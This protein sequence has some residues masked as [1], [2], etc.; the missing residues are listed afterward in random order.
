MRFNNFLTAAASIAAFAGLISDARATY[1]TSNGTVQVSSDTHIAPPL[2]NIQQLSGPTSGGYVYTNQVS[3]SPFTSGNIR[4]ISV[5]RVNEA[6]LNQ[7]NIKVGMNASPGTALV[8]VT[9]LKGTL[10]GGGTASFSQ[11]TLFLIA[12]PSATFS[13]TDPDT[14]AKPADAAI[15]AQYSLVKDSVINGP[16]QASVP[17]IIGTT[18]DPA[19]TT[20]ALMNLSSISVLQGQ[21]VG[22]FLFT[23]NSLPV[24]NS[25]TSGDNFIRDVQNI[26]GLTSIHDG[27]YVTITQN[28]QNITGLTDASAGLALGATDLTVLNDYAGAASL[29]DL[30]LPGTAFA[31]AYGATNTGPPG[32][33]F[34]P[35][36]SGA[37]TNKTGDFLATLASN[38]NIVTVPVPE[39]DSFVLFGLG[40]A[41]LAAV[42]FRN[43]KK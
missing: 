36:G 25:P 15:L 21:P 32:N 10:V 41:G 33:T 9:A 39:P 17:P 7:S 11:G 34:F 19:T 43:R 22:Q 27:L 3:G 18:F 5:Q 29:G 35:G 14:W 31:T 12:V 28:V 24:Q 6:I 26:N 2:P 4:T 42:R 30:G 23:E 38:A 8:A 13:A 40:I 37:T 20:A 16:D 1:M